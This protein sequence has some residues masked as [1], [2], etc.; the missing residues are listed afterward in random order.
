MSIPYQRRRF[1]SVVLGC[2]AERLSVPGPNGTEHFAVV[3][4]DGTGK[5]NRERR[6]QVLEQ[7]AT[8]I[9]RQGEPGEV[10][11]KL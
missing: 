4:M 10:E 7:I 3:P 1:W 11:V 9:D 5:Q 2:T 6:Q 8:H